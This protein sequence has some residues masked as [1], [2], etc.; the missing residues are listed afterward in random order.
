[1]VARVLLPK[2]LPKLLAESKVTCRIIQPDYTVT[3]HHNSASGYNG[4]INGAIRQTI[5]NS[6]LDRM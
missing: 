4:A 6:N 1:M 2:Y 3:L 5:P